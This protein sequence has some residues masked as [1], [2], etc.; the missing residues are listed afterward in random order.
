MRSGNI[1][2]RRAFDGLMHA[3]H[4]ASARR[5][6]HG[7]PGAIEEAQ[8]ERLLQHRRGG[9]DI[10]DGAT[11]TITGSVAQVFE[12]LTYAIHNRGSATLNLSAF[13]LGSPSNALG[14]ILV[15]PPATVAAI[16][17]S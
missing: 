7:A 12:T 1:G 4:V 9:A 16:S 15:T 2:D 8:R 3:E 13:Q 5:Q 14:E 17:R 6:A 11:D 10:A